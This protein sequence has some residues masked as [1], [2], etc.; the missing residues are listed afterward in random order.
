MTE[1]LFFEKTKP[2]LKPWYRSAIWGINTIN[3][4][5]FIAGLHTVQWVGW[6]NLLSYWVFPTSWNDE[7]VNMP[8]DFSYIVI[9]ILLKFIGNT[10][11]AEEELSDPVI[12]E[13]QSGIPRTFSWRRKFRSYMIGHLHFLAFLSFWAGSWNIFDYYLYYCEYCWQREI[14]YIVLAPVV[15]FFVQEGIS[16]ES[17][18]WLFARR[19]AKYAGDDVEA[20]SLMAKDHRIEHV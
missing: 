10:W 17:L 2:I 11:F 19:G 15:L 13:W 14:Y 1:Q 7:L 4:C 20:Q 12:A 6:W 9:G 5:I 8:R 18:Y 3:A 16:L